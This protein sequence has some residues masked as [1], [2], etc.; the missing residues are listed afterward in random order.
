MDRITAM[1]TASGVDPRWL[2]VELTESAVMEDAQ[3][4]LASLHRL[5]DAGLRLFVDDFGTG[6]SSLA[7]L[8]KLPVDAVKIDRSFVTD[9]LQ[10]RGLEK[11]VRSTI[12]LAHDLDLEVV[13]EGVETEAVWN[14][15]AELGC[16]VAQGYFI[17]APMPP[18]EFAEWVRRQ[19]AG[20]QGR[21][22]CAGPR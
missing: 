16:D 2:E 19:Q 5:H 10:E 4:A 9:M 7:Y 18:D 6:Y 15:L 17:G 11:I 14:R 1:L 12:D 20:R 21:R 22:A 8:Q 3:T 13:A